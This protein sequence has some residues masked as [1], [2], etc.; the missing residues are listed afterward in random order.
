MKCLN[1]VTKME[2]DGNELFTRLMAE[3]NEFTVQKLCGEIHG[4]HALDYV[5]VRA[6]QA[7]VHLIMRT[8]EDREAGLNLWYVNLETWKD[9]TRTL[10]FHWI[11]KTD[12]LNNWAERTAEL[13][14]AGLTYGTFGIWLTK[15]TSKPRFSSFCT[16]AA[17]EG[18]DLKWKVLK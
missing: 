16:L 10:V 9:Y 5:L 18:F 1:G 15:G 14:H 13:K 12:D 2:T 8:P 3:L 4:N 11:N 17:L 6:K 7:G